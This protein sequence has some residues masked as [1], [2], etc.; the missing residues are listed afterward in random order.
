MTVEAI[1]EVLGGV[2]AIQSA[3]KTT[4]DLITLTREGLPVKALAAL[5]KELNID[6]KSVGRILGIPT[7]TWM[8]R[9]ASGAR[10]T[11]AESDRTLRFARVLAFAVDVLG[12]AA[13][14]S[15]W[16]QTENR[17]LLG[18]APLELLDTDAGVQTVETLLG[19]IAY[20]LYS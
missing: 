13:N 3:P 16:L 4:A 10:L 12:D 1:A 20:G 14:A 17:A 8:R 9:T 2:D 11:A 15:R 18:S 5:T 7:R 6:R 19:R